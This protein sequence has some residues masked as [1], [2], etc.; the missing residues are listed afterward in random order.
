[1]MSKKTNDPQKSGDKSKK[2]SFLDAS[3]QILD[4]EK[5]LKSSEKETVKNKKESID[6]SDNMVEAEPDINQ[7]LKLGI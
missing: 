2:W 7:L 5:N 6:N 1:M 4:E 3:K